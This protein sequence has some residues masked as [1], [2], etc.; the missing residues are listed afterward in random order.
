MYNMLMNKVEILAPVG[1]IQM[2]ET[3]IANN[4][5]AVYFGLESFN[6]RAKADNFHSDN[7]RNIIQRCHLFGIKVYVTVNTLI[8]EDEMDSVLLMIEK[9][10]KAN[11]D[12][13]I[14]QDLGLAYLLKKKFPNIVLHA[15]TQMGI[16]NEY[17]A[18]VLEKIG[19]ERVVVARET[20]LEDIKRIRQNTNLE[21]EAFVQ[22]A[23]CVCYSGSCYL[24][25]KLKNKSGN[26][27][28]CLQLCRLPYKLVE[29]GK[30]KK[31]GYLISPRDIS[32]ICKLKELIDAGVCSLKI[33]GRLRRPAYLAQAVNSVRNVLEYQKSLETED[34]NLKKVFSRGDFNKGIY[35]ESKAQGGIINNAVN[36]HL[37]IKIGS[38][39]SVEKF[40]EINA[41]TIKSS[42]N[43][44]TGDGLKFVFN[45]SQ[46]SMGVGN[47]EKKK[48]GTYVVFAK[49]KPM[50]G[51]DV[52]LTLDAEN[53]QMLLNKERKIPITINAEVVCGK[54]LSIEITTGDIKAIYEGDTVEMA[55]SKALS[56]DQISESLSKT[57]GTD[58]VVSEIT[59]NTKDA[60]VAKSKLNEARREALELLKNKIIDDYEQKKCKTFIKNNQKIEKIA[61]FNNHFNFYIVNNL[62]KIDDIHDLNA[63]IIYAPE[64]YIEI[65]LEC[66]KTIINSKKIAK[67]YLYLP[68]VANFRDLKV[69]E[70]VLNKFS[71]NEI[72]IAAGSIYGIYFKN[73][74]YDIVALQNNNIS[75]SWSAEQLF[76]LGIDNFVS[77]IE[78]NLFE[79]VSGGHEYVGNP[80]LMT[81][82]MCPFI[83]NVNSNCSNCLFNKNYE[84]IMDDG[85]RFNIRRTKVADCYFELY[86]NKKIAN[87]KGDS[88]IIDLR[89]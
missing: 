70:N 66:I 88:Y 69:I 38:V 45:N 8:A 40:K 24:S 60:F 74:G 54:K 1:N 29:S 46:Y 47:V 18:K 19:F 67:L 58:F 72:G 83:E 30:I 80:A 27:G 37:G 75:N 53:E 65:D 43:I 9:A 10:H 21:I 61:Q 28:E 89:N 33:E 22:G 73:L 16:C 35:L 62:Q 17:G 5:D 57:G 13:F 42:H 23:L 32:L 26:R 12:A 25:S 71:K 52:Y 82:V 49:V 86:Q 3:A 78:N 84:L 48:S 77:S 87:P 39:L 63:R 59:V 36:N 68:V 56:K 79:S 15:S 51:A 41:I 44:M 50:V 64:S 76:N 4:A 81:I 20:T 6:A 34:F 7:V 31:Q 55:Q 11:A 14:I 85:T 2:L